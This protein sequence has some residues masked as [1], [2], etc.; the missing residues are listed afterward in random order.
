MSPAEA[1]TAKME[2]CA[3]ASRLRQTATNQRRTF[4]DAGRSFVDAA[5]VCGRPAALRRSE[6]DAAQSAS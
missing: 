3:F 5:A 2:N 1:A 4:V 6:E